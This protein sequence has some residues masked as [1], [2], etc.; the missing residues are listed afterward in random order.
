MT[1]SS[2][3]P[4]GYTDGLGRAAPDGEVPEIPARCRDG[5]RWKE[6]LSSPL[7]LLGSVLKAAVRTGM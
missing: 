1:D 7:R 5:D 6:C 4:E 2:S 3:M